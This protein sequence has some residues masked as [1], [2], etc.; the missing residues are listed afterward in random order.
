[1]EIV[2][3]VYDLDLTAT[4]ESSS[5][6]VDNIL[7]HPEVSSTNVFSELEVFHGSFSSLELAFRLICGTNHYGPG[8]SQCIDT[9]DTTGHYTCNTTAGGKVCLEGYQDPQKNCTNC[10]PAETCSE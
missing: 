8:C 10:T 4:I 5:D 3:T 9:N 2:F 7:V 1:M 6:V